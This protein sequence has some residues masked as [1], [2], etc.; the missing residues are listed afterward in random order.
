VALEHVQRKL[1]A[2][3][4]ADVAGY[5]RLTGADEEGTMRR[6]RALRAE[7]ID[8]AI[9]THRGHIVKTMGDGFLVEFSSA[10]DAV[11]CFLE[12]QRGV[13]ARNADFEPDK[14]IEFRVGVHVGDVMVQPDGDLLGDGVN[15]AARLESIAEPGGICLSEDAYHQVRDRLNEEFID[16]GDKELKN[17]DRPVRVFSVTTGSGSLAPAVHPSAAVKSAP[18]RLSIVVLPFTNLGS[19]P[20][21][22]YF[23]DGV[24]ESLT[25]DLSRVAGAFVIARNTAFNYKGKPFDVKDIGRELNVSYVLEG[26]VQRSGN[27]LRVNVQLIDAETGNHLWAERFEK[28]LADL[29]DMQDEIVSRL[30]GA[31]NTQLVTAEA[32]RG[33]RAPQPDS[34]DLYF[35]GM[36]CANKGLNPEYM[37]Q[38]RGFFERAL[39]LDPG[40]TEALVGIAMVDTLCGSNFMSDDPAASLAAA[41]ATLTQ[42]LSLAPNHAWAR[43][44]MGAVQISTNRAAQGIAECERALALDRNLANAHGIIGLAKYLIGR[45]EETETHVHEAL[46]LSPGD[47]FVYF[48]MTFAG[49]AKLQLGRDEEA[50]SWFRRGIETNQNFP[51]AHFYLAAALAHLGQLD[52]AQAALKAGLALDPA[53]TLSRF[54]AGAASDNQT[55]LE[56]R[57]RVIQGMREAGALEG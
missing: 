11:R 6:L 41:E 54:R 20:E 14:R 42:T 34:M 48:W 21:Q 45:G 51:P 2:I 55:Y 10:V 35:Q 18:P 9:Q 17:I 28:P 53:F 29:F 23:V 12:V 4:A 38:A 39:A 15:I 43:C 5:S 46:R 16:L 13:P 36:A 30:A 1:A 56:Q 47:T 32:R 57:E 33:E 52:E 31:L 44:L 3:V 49:V 25:T 19:D 40:N 50:V 26:S 22:E 8:P 37:A 7:L 24:T 27:R